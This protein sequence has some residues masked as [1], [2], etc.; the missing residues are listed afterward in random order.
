M[1]YE[2]KIEKT[3]RQ[4]NIQNQ[5]QMNRQ[6]VPVQNQQ[7]MNRQ[8]VPVQNRQQANVEGNVLAQAIAGNVMVGNNNAVLPPVAPQEPLEQENAAMS[9]K[10]KKIVKQRQQEETRQQEQERLRRQ[11]EAIQQG[12]EILRQEEETRQREKEEVRRREQEEK[13][14]QREE[15]EKRWEEERIED[16]KLLFEDGAILQL[17]KEMSQE[18]DATLSK[19]K[20]KYFLMV[21]AQRLMEL[22]P[23]LE[24]EY[25][26]TVDYFSDAETCKLIIA[27]HAVTPEQMELL[28]VVNQKIEAL[29]N[30]NNENILL[31]VISFELSNIFKEEYIVLPGLQE[32][33]NEIME[34]YQK[35]EKIELL[36]L[37][38]LI[39]TVDKAFPFKKEDGKN[40][41]LLEKGSP[42]AYLREEKTLEEYHVQVQQV[43]KE[44]NCT[45]QEAEEQVLKD[46]KERLRESALERTR[47]GSVVSDVSAEDWK[48]H[49][50]AS[51]H[52]TLPTGEALQTVEESHGYLYVEEVEPGIM[53]LHPTIPETIEIKVNGVGKEYPL[54][55][56]YN[57]FIKSIVSQMIDEDGN[58]QGEEVGKMKK[59]FE[60]F[61][62]DGD[63]DGLMEVL[64]DGMKKIFTDEEQANNEAN[65]LFVFLK[66]M[67][68]AEGSDGFLVNFE[69]ISNI[70]E[71]ATVLKASEDATY[72]VRIERLEKE[73][74]TDENLSAE[75]I[76]Q[77]IKQIPNAPLTE[78][79]EKMQTVMEAEGRSE[80]EIKKYM[81]ALT[82]F[83]ADVDNAVME[84]LRIRNMDVNSKDVPLPNQ[85]S[86]NGYFY[87][88]LSKISGHGMMS[89][90]YLPEFHVDTHAR[91]DLEY[92][93]AHSEKFSKFKEN[94]EKLEKLSENFKDKEYELTEKDKELIVQVL[95]EHFK[96]PYHLAA[97]LATMEDGKLITC[98]SFAAE[99][100]QAAVSPFIQRTAVGIYFG[101][102]EKET[103]VERNEGFTQY[104]NHDNPILVEEDLRAGLKAAFKFQKIPGGVNYSPS[105]K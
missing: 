103:I 82:S 75:E 37:N 79:L 92:I 15:D 21:A 17:M 9:K 33:E 54:R 36:G 98:E 38:K 63:F 4:T 93:F 102:A 65:E 39:K 8:A 85:C 91:E 105:I 44:K 26:R 42:Y 41:G 27:E 20:M 18:T 40:I 45:R 22:K 55:R 77:I 73:L 61:F 1:D 94:K 58:L 72:K 14:R 69:G 5:Q 80:A 99:T 52:Y 25:F 88:N 46:R 74:S 56:N 10:E 59:M 84:L 64:Q 24:E 95:D 78:Q 104:Y 2:V 90:T 53:E 6:A 13:R 19:E 67:Y 34:Q 57:L 23:E 31:R 81:D 29:E 7:Q 62:G 3:Q 48:K 60:G 70:W 11:E 100:V 66:D 96:Y 68:S 32:A 89:I 83:H 51:F 76:K 86:A 12:E 49:G 50:G 16:R 101:K 30:L 47:G 87:K 71:F 28:E 43:M 97:Q 35:L